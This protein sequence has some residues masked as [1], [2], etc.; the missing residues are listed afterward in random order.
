M[1]SRLLSLIIVLTGILIF[2]SIAFAQRGNRN[3]PGPPH[4]PHDLS[5]VWSMSGGTLNA[6]N[7]PPA[8]TPLAKS[9]FDSN[10]PSYGERAVPPALGNDPIGDCNPLGWPR[11]MYFGRPVEF[12]QLPDRVVQ[13]WEWTHVWRE[14]WT[15]GRKLPADPDPRWYGYSAGRWEGDTFVVD[16][17][18]IDARSWLDHFGYAHSDEMKVQ[19]RWHRLD[20]DNME[21]TFTIEDPKMYPKGWASDK[22][23]WRLQPKSTYT[24]DGWTSLREEFCAPLDEGSFNDKIRNPAGRGK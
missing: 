6:T 2:S 17:R 4:D 13:F 11:L 18:G 5:G 7:E 15:D 3:P 14:I 9:K 21:V 16:T 22:K 19:E 10:K 12:I 20:R 1:R 24:F 23:M 8:M